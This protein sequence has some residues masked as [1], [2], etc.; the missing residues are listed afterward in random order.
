MTSPRYSISRA[1]QC[2]FR[3]EGARRVR[4]VH[5]GRSR[6][7]RD[8]ADARATGRCLSVRGRGP[9]IAFAL[10]VVLEVLDAPETLAALP[11]RGTGP[12]RYAVAR[13]AAAAAVA[14]RPAGLR[15]AKRRR[16]REDS[17]HQGRRRAR[18]AA[19]RPHADDLRRRRRSIEKIPSVLSARAGGE[20]GSPRSIAA[21]TGAG[22]FLSC[23]RSNC[24]GRMSCGG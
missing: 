16:P 5:S 13:H 10:D 8:A 24:S 7:A 18:R 23:R 21:R 9:G 3:A 15:T 1:D 11:P 17:R 6:C 14:A 19:G 22:W 4:A 20:A 2:G 12:R